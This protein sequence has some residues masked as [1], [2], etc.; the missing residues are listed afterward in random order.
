MSAIDF[1]SKNMSW[2]PKPVARLFEK[3]MKTL[4]ALKKMV[5]A[6]NDKIAVQLEH[7]LKPYK[8]IYTR[9]SVLPSEGIE[10]TKVLELVRDMAE[11][12]RPRWEE[13]Y[14]SGGIYSGDRE[15]I[16]FLNQ[17]YSLHSQD[18]PLHGDL[19]PS[20]TKY[21]A[22]I[23]AMVAAMQGQG[24]TTDGA[25]IVGTVT[26]GGTESILLAMKTYRDKARAERGI[27]EPEM[28]LPTSAHVAFDKAAQYFGIKQVK[29]NLDENF[30]AKLDEVEKAITKNTVAIVGS[31]PGFPHGAF[32]PIEAMSN[33][34]FKHGIP[35]H[36]DCCLGGFVV[37]FAEK[38]GYNVPKVD[39]RLPGVTSM[40]VDTHKYGYA[41]KGTSVVLYRNEDFRH[42]QYYTSTE[43][44]GGLYMSPTLA[45]SRPG[46]L[47]AACWATMLS[48]GEK[49][50]LNA[51]KAIY[52]TA[53]KIKKEAAEIPGIKILGE[54]HFVIAFAS[55]TVNIYEVLDY[56]TKKHWNL[57]GLQKPECFHIALTLRHTQ[58]G[59]A[60]RFIAD[61]K[62]AM[63]H[64][65][66][67]PG[68]K[69]GMAPVYGMASSLP[70]RGMVADF[71][72]KYLD[73]VYKV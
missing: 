27:T 8:N 45:G 21:E 24:K 18:N 37:P 64:V 38:L 7:S 73:V 16:E 40:S 44:P 49:G 1:V 31:A 41:A 12:E 13:G 46:G 48:V 32:D 34:A 42:Y 70:F 6:E 51:V 50:Y 65:K 4:P 66:A 30:R 22:E 47:S 20:A 28:I 72:K 2:L 3:Q 29:I 52:E 58:A 33:I 63:A 11:R 54:P 57:N 69:D 23:V 9:Y 15:H 68:G 53:D 60:E 14:V 55:D 35:F 62:E 67:N 56:M 25:E 43:W 39:F 71:L 59:V 19:F 10:R 61:L 26:S 17:V 5:D 36:T